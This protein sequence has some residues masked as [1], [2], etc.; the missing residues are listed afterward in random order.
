MKDKQQLPAARHSID[1][2]ARQLKWL[3]R[4]WDS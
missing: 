3:H 1:S 2:E 4:T